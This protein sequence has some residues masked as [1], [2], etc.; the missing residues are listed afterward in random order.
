MGGAVIRVIHVSRRLHLPH[1]PLCVEVHHRDE[2][3]LGRSGHRERRR[4]R[5]LDDVELLGQHPHSVVVK[6]LRRNA[7]GPTPR[8]P[9]V[10]D[11]V[12]RPGGHPCQLLADGHHGGR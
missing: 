11:G 5:R 8:D 6:S 7:V 1:S 12:V 2:C 4:I 3:S 9:A 10:I